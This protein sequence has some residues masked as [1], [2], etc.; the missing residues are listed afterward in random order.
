VRITMLAPPWIPVPPPAYGGIE[1]VLELLASEL[2]ARGH[3]VTLAAAA[4]SDVPAAEVRVPLERVPDEIG[5]SHEEWLHVTRALELADGTD[6]V[7][8]HTGP[9]G[10]LLGA[11]SGVPSLH[12]TH[13]PIQGEAGEIYRRLSGSAEALRLVAISD[14]Q[15][16]SAPD[17][18]W[19]GVC[20]NGLDVEAVPFRERPDDYL[21]FLGRLAPEKGAAE[22]IAIAREA[23]LPLLIAAKCREPAEQAYFAE[24]V[25]PEL[26][27]G[28][29]W[30]G[31]VGGGEKYGLLG[32]ARA[33]VFPIDW[34]EPFG[35]VMV[36]AMACGTPVLATSRGSV[37][38]V[39]ADGETGFVRDEP[40]DLVE[41]VALLGGIDR[42][43]CRAHVAASFSAAAMGDGYERVIQRLLDGGSDSGS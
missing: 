2:S 36:E 12:V 33:L 43:R 10:A 29:R 35:M 4:G 5:R 31:E 30:L 6:V 15:R 26:G 7:I 8:D 34:P 9:A 20:Y 17:L 13:G 16:R 41:T 18:P 14:A 38:E 1:Q 11:A 32:G 21:L 39:V 37:P 22:A 42:G 27:P 40:G 23:G 25:E 3:E 24:H 19:L 28:V